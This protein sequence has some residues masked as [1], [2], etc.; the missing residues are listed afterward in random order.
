MPGSPERDYETVTVLWGLLM[1]RVRIPSVPNPGMSSAFDY[2]ARRG[3]PMLFQVTE[4]NSTQ[5]LYTTFLALHV[6]PDSLEER[7]TKSKNVVQTVGGWVEFNWPDELSSFSASGSTGAF[8][9]PESG[10]T[11]GNERRARSPSGS[12]PMAPGRRGTIAW[13][14]REDFLELFRSNGCVYNS[15]GQ[16]AIRGRVMCIFDRGIFLG[17]FTTFEETEDDVHPFSFMLSWEFKVESTVYRIPQQTGTP[18]TRFNAG[19]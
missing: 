12:D 14:R 1:P 13:E 16:P 8:F 7:M 15:E 9:S 10:L 18:G 5:P 6:N 17:H 3:R 11:A 4:P 2:E 19:V